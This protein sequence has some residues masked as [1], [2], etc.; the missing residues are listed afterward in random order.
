MT[1]RFLERTHGLGAAEALQF[2]RHPNRILLL[3]VLYFDSVLSGSGIITAVHL[4]THVV[5]HLLQSLSREKMCV[6]IC[7][8]FHVSSWKGVAPSMTRFDLKFSRSTLSL[9]SAGSFALRS[10]KL[11]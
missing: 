5:G 3:N 2:M 4:S 8:V 6:P 1:L 11:A 7:T 10:S 9:Y